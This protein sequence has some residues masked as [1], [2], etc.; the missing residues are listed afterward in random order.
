MLESDHKEGWAPWP[1][2]LLILTNSF[3]LE[4]DIHALGGKE[5]NSAKSGAGINKRQKQCL[6]ELASNMVS[7][8]EYEF[9]KYVKLFPNSDC[10][11]HGILY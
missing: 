8:G 2:F 10:S 5:D 7:N 6:G 1:C 4:L 11:S 3:T 9:N